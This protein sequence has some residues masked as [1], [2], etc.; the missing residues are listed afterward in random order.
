MKHLSYIILFICISSIT[1]AQNNIKSAQAISDKILLAKLISENAENGIAIVMDLNY[2]SIVSYSGFA[3][4]GKSFKKDTSLLTKAIEPGGLMS[5]LSAAVLIDN[6]GVLLDDSIDL[7]GGQTNF[8]NLVVR[9]QELHGIRYASL[10]RVIAESSNV[11]IA[12][13]VKS[14]MQGDQKLDIFKN[15]VK[16]YF[17]SD[18]GIN[19]SN[20]DESNLPFWA[21]GYGI[22][23]TPL[24]IF[25]FYNRIV[26]NDVTL[27]NHPETLKQIQIAL[28]E[29]V[30]NGT[31]KHV[32]QGTNF[33]VAGKTAT[34]LVANKNGYGN[35]QYFA[36]FV[37]YA[38]K[39]D[40]KYICLVM[41][42]CK[43]H[44]PNHFGSSVAAPVFKSIIE[45]LNKD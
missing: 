27:F 8:G 6:F 5:P 13:F 14:R 4:V 37:G 17:V 19:F 25:E 44:A 1:N 32:F 43:P 18:K 16:G 31:A 20:N 29:V 7:E 26:N 42:K 10:L 36:S 28:E 35:A 9:D 24:Q 34:S 38:P 21:F 40:P 30:A 39:A 15:K 3:K 33:E 45:N 11:G 12:K 2:D 41:I 22:G 23:I